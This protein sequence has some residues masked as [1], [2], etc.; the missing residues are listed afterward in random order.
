M[1]TYDILIKEEV[2]YKFQVE[3]NDMCDAEKKAEAEFLAMS[4]AKKIAISKIED[5]TVYSMA[6]VGRKING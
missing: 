3:A 5:R 1:R 2:H 4:L 6:N